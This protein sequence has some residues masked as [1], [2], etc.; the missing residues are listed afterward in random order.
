MPPGGHTADSAGIR[1][2]LRAPWLQDEMKAIADRGVE[3]A[4]QLA[5]PHVRTGAFAESI[6]AEVGVEGD[7]VAAYLVSDDPAAIAIEYGT[8]DTEGL[9]ILSRAAIAIEGGA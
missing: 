1:Q 9:F 3:I 2:M 7:R 5:L 6:H 4:Q 8:T